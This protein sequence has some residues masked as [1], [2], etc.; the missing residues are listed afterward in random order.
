MESGPEVARSEIECQG[1]YSDGTSSAWSRGGELAGSR[2]QG[3]P[4]VGF[5]VRLSGKSSERFGGSYRATFT[6]GSAAG[7][8]P[9]GELCVST[10]RAPLEALLI[11]LYRREA[12]AG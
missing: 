5:R 1:I 10:N 9:L 4:L 3:R 2:G 6:D 12:P 7:P 11:S 8:T